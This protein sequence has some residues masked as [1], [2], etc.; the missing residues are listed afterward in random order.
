MNTAATLK[1]RFGTLRFAVLGYEYPDAEGQGDR[2]WL[3]ARVEWDSASSNVTHEGAILEADELRDLAAELS[4]AESD[5]DHRFLE[6]NFALHLARGSVSITLNDAVCDGASSFEVTTP[7]DPADVIAF[8]EALRR[9]AQQFPPREAR[10]VRA[11]SPARPGLA[12]A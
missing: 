1:G 9:I 10:P 3:V 5:R 8:G 6:P 12:A 4:G 11:A 7:V 2:N